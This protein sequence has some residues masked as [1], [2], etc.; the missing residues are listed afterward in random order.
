[1]IMKG[2][3]L[4]MILSTDMTYVI[5]K[6][7]ICDCEKFDMWY[8]ICAHGMIPILLVP[9]IMDDRRGRACVDHGGW[10]IERRQATGWASW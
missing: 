8:V 10:A 9:L 2:S 3:T 5:V 6:E 1:M 4:L 7:L